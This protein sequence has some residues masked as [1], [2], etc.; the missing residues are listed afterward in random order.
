MG[1]G[2]TALNAVIGAVVTVATTFVPFSPVIG[3]AVAGYLQGADASAA[4]KVGILSGLVATVPFLLA[5]PFLSALI[6][7]PFLPILSDGLGVLVGVFGVFLLFAVL[8]A[9]VYFVGLSAVGGYL[10][11][12]IESETDL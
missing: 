5:V 1:N 9:V 12:Y 8:T 7:L 4:L 3:G 6:G 2:D 11:W 10:G